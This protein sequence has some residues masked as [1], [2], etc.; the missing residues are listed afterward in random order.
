ME[1]GKSI[2]TYEQQRRVIEDCAKD[3]IT[4]TNNWN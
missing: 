1:M 4:T 3:K 2:R